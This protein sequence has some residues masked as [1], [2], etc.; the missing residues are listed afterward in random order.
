V[1]VVRADSSFQEVWDTFVDAHPQAGPYHR[2][3][4]S[5]AVRQAYGF[6]QV[7]L[8]ALRE[9]QVA[10]V[11]PLV[12]MKLPGARGRLVSLPYCDFGG[13]LSVDEG[14]NTL[15]IEYAMEFAEAQSVKEVVL[16]RQTAG[17]S[18]TGK[19][20]MR[21]ALPESSTLLMQSFSAKLRSQ[22]KKPQRE[23]LTV[24]R[25]GEELLEHFYRV[26]AK[27]MRDLGSPAHS[28]GWF[29]RVVRGFQD[30]G[31]VWVAYLPDGRPAAAAITLD[32]GRVTYVPWASSVREY[33]PHNPNMLLYWAMLS[34]AAEA[35]QRAFEFG[36]CTPGEGTH[37]FKK[38]WGA[39]PLDLAWDVYDPATRKVKCAE[40]GA[41]ASTLRRM[42]ESCWRRLPLW[43]ANVAGPLL[44]RYI[45]L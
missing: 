22:I 36:R 24:I 35:G 25:G 38:Q 32:Q 2:W 28:L 21:L 10:G 34:G 30:F 37:R 29:T 20:L 45:S 6:H 44:R 39:E 19:V 1:R 11:L 40:S 26:F 33:N 23:G 14:T 15:L 17:A 42:A 27:N 9:D 16:R 43:A 18:G 5:Q 3:A 31:R 7:S 12:H 8:V 4:W 13:P 41:R